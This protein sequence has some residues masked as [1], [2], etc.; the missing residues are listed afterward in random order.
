[1]GD[2]TPGTSH[3][4]PNHLGCKVLRVT[5]SHKLISAA[6]FASLSLLFVFAVFRRAQNTV[7]PFEVAP[8]PK[9]ARILTAGE[10]DALLAAD[11]DIV[12]RVQ[13]IPREVKADYTQLTTEPFEMVNPGQAMSTDLILAGVPNKKLVLVGIADECAVLI[14]IRGGY[15]DTVNAAVFSHKGTGGMWGATIEDYSVHDIPGLRKAVDEGRFKV[16]Q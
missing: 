8:L 13:Q 14:F 12:H 1:M 7:P 2:N 9:D 10:I 16:W 4:S 11:F 6:V 3:F 5:T 15:A